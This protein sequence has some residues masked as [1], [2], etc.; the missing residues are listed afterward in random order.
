[1]DFDVKNCSW[2]YMTFVTWAEFED[3]LCSEGN[4]VFPSVGERVLY[5][6]KMND[7]RI[8]SKDALQKLIEQATKPC[9]TDTSLDIV[10]R[11][12]KQALQA[13]QMAPLQPPS[14]SRPKLGY[15]NR[16][17]QMMLSVQSQAERIASDLAA[18]RQQQ[19]RSID[20][21]F[22]TIGSKMAAKTAQGVEPGE[23]MDL[24]LDLPVGSAEED[25][26]LRSNALSYGQRALK[27]QPVPTGVTAAQRQQQAL[28]DRQFV[29]EDSLRA[30]FDAVLRGP[31]SEEVVVEGFD[32]PVTRRLFQSLARHS[33]LN[34]E[35]I[36]YYMLLLKDRNNK[37]LDHYKETGTRPDYRPSHFYNNFFVNKL[38]DNET[39]GYMYSY[40]KRWSRRFDTFAM[41]KIFCPINISNTHWTLAVIY[42]QQ[43][44]VRYIDS[45]SGSGRRY[46]DGLFRYLK[47]EHLDKKKAPLPDPESWSLEYGSDCPQ[48]QNG[49]DC[50]VF[51]I[52]A[53]DYISDDLPLQYSQT[54]V[55]KYWRPK[56]GASLLR[57]ELNYKLL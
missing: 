27:A 24:D 13:I 19:L 39:G 17:N 16:M 6:K 36:N 54:E 1:M 38:L 33:W 8:F 2:Q 7:G 47:E 56:I 29:A 35:I 41:D 57:K 49:V 43:K 30:R 23:S 21:I 52:C 32:I 20:D 48:Q 15:V 5:N 18:H 40:V 10:S 44:R 14:Q 26:S 9:K 45:M 46:V 37:L 50:G 28:Q 55:S 3:F 51:T 22:S 12:H 11:Q 42:V 31:G 25:P 4:I 53:A 34:D